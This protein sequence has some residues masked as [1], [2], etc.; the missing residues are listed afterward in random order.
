M[1]E[2]MH[3]STDTTDG[4]PS[5]EKQ[6][7][8]SE[9]RRKDAQ[10]A[11][12]PVQQENARLKAELA[13]TNTPLE[14]VLTPEQTAALE[15]LKFTNPDEWRRQMNEQETKAEV[16]REKIVANSTK[17]ETDKIEAQNF[18]K[19]N[20]GID[21]KIMVQIVPIAIQQRFENGELT[22]KETLDIGKRLLDGAPI[23]SILTP[24]SPQIGKVAGS[25]KPSE[26][27]KTEQVKIDWGSAII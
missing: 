17:V 14:N 4:G 1:S 2:D 23:A 11:L 6:L 10:A 18:Y 15:D 24:D 9:T 5:L 25:D 21:P 12:T 16:A 20:P 3:A 22:M 27:A 8:V 13:A 19:E 7:E 26:K